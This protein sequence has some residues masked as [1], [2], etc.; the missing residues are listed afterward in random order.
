MIELLTAQRQID[1]SAVNCDGLAIAL[2]YFY[3]RKYV[4][5]AKRTS[6][7]GAGMLDAETRDLIDTTARFV[8]RMDDQ[9]R[10]ALRTR[11]EGEFDVSADERQ[12]SMGL[13]YITADL[14]KLIAVVVELAK[15]PPPP[16]QVAEAR[17]VAAAGAEQLLCGTRTIR[18]ISDALGFDDPESIAAK[19]DT[20]ALQKAIAELIV[21]EVQRANGR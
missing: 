19:V 7:R 16:D 18:K 3:H 11:L 6:P 5:R 10:A 20:Q 4:I 13:S 21:A 14:D 17:R 1:P 12:R 15:P 2:H 9:F 8:S